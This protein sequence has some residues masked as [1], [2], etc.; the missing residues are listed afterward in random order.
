MKEHIKRFSARYLERRRAHPSGASTIDST[1]ARTPDQTPRTTADSSVGSRAVSSADHT[2]NSTYSSTPN[3][4]SSSPKW[5]SRDLWEKAR[6]RLSENDRKIIHDHVGSISAGDVT[7]PN[8]LLEVAKEKQKICED[9]RWNFEFGGRKIRLQNV[10]DRVILWLDKFKTVVDV[11]INAD[12]LHAGL[13]W[14]GIKF[15]LLVCNAPGFIPSIK[16]SITF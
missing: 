7:V 14:A 2:T 16:Y 5:P 12:P 6:Q 9:K 15:L 3:A 1:T 4:V 13:P 11:A 10:A 8:T